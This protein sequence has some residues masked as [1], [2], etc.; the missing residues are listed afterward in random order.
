MRRREMRKGKEEG[1]QK[2]QRTKPCCGNFN[3]LK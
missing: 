3:A 1:T 2:Q